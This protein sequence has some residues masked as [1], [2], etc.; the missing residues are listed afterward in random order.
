[1]LRS[2]EKRFRRAFARGARAAGTPRG[3]GLPIRRRQWLQQAIAG[4]ALLGGAGALFS[5]CGGVRRGDLDADAAPAGAL[6]SL[7]PRRRSILEHAALAPSG[8]NSQPW[9][10]R[11]LEPDRWVIGADPAR[12]L[13]AVDPE[14]REVML[15]LGAFAENLALAAGALGLRAQMRTLA[16]TGFDTEAIEVRL[17]ES[18]PAAYPL[19]RITRRRTVKNGFLPEEIRREDLAALAG[20][21]PGACF[22][23]PRGSE[24]ARCIAAAAVES[25]RVQAGRDAAQAELVRWL[26]LSAADARRHRD[27]LTTEGMEITGAAGWIVRT[28]LAPE[29]FMQ[30]D[31]RR[32]G[33]E[34]AAKQA[35]EGGGWLVITSPGEAA[36]DWI[37]AGRKF[38]RLALLA[39]ERRIALHPMTQVLEERVGREAIAAAHGAGLYPQ[40]VLRVGYLADYPEPVSLRRPPAWFV[41]TG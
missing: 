14:N 31:A 16:R 7:D 33:L 26:R 4:A 22:Y 23:F 38:E 27:G 9:T 13:P 41:Q 36:G 28:F 3:G 17:A 20:H 25:F 34:M 39:R 18:Q 19:E 21:L 8:H 40:L 2:F 32:R 1:M 12:R 10:V 11:I 24:H 15:S 30:P 35:Q 5:A 29:D 6:A 37:E